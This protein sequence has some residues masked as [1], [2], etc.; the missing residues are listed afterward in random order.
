MTRLVVDSSLLSQL[1][2]A[3]EPVEI[4]DAQG[5]VFGTFQ[6]SLQEEFRSTPPESDE[7]LA[8]RAKIRKGVSF[9]EMIARAEQ[10]T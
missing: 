2:G 6:P 10:G 1:A 7:E 4:C 9:A 8:R 5:T 3:R